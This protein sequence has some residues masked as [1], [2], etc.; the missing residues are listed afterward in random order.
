MVKNPINTDRRAEMTALL[1][2]YNPL[3]IYEDTVD[4]EDLLLA[5]RK[6]KARL[7]DPIA[8]ELLQFKGGLIDLMEFIGDGSPQLKKYYL[9]EWERLRHW[10]GVLATEEPRPWVV[11]GFGTLEQVDWILDWVKKSIVFVRAFAQTYP[12]KRMRQ[13]SWKEKIAA[14]RILT[15][16]MFRWQGIFAPV[17]VWVRTILIA[18]LLEPAKLCFQDLAT[19]TPSKVEQ[20]T[21]AS[22]DNGIRESWRLYM[23]RYCI[24]ERGEHKVGAANIGVV[25]GSGQ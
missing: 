1:S 22:P 3:S 25:E 9:E 11:P 16:H 10:V 19:K 14:C 13:V 5:L 20:K 7:T 4:P 6:L 12:G 24:V 17:A 8:H 15:T 18:P 2:K 21:Q 23:E